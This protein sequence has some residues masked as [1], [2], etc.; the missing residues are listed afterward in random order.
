MNRLSVL[1]IDRGDFVS[2]RRHALGV[3]AVFKL[4]ITVVKR[5]DNHVAVAHI[6]AGFD[7]AAVARNAA[8]RAKG[9]NIGNIDTRIAADN[10]TGD[11]KMIDSPDTGNIGVV[12]AYRLDRKSVV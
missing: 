3:G 4:I 8:V 9:V 6:G 12:A 11:N 2:H 10:L 1:T 7:H 5:C